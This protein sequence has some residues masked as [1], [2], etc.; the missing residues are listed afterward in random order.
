MYYNDQYLTPQQLKARI[1]KEQASSEAPG[2]APGK[3]PARKKQPIIKNLMMRLGQSK[4]SH[5]KTRNN[6]SD[7]GVLRGNTTSQ[8]TTTSLTDTADNMSNSPEQQ[9]TEMSSSSVTNTVDAN[10]DAPQAT[11]ETA[12]D[13]LVARGDKLMDRVQ[14]IE[15]RTVELS[16][17]LA[18][19]PRWPD[20]QLQPRKM[21]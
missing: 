17:R 7:V 8:L 5:S 2:E 4:T 14:D 3:T 1:Q 19:R 18:I 16:A 12:V 13:K 11:I 9:P 10:I 15:R 20:H 6:Q 21:P